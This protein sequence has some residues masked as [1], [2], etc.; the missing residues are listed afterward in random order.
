MILFKLGID[1]GKYKTTNHLQMRGGRH[2]DVDSYYLY[3]MSVMAKTWGGT[4]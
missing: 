4:S 3:A 1:I 2:L